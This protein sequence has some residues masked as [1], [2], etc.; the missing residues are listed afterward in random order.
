[1]D[2]REFL[3]DAVL[4]AAGVFIGPKFG[5]IDGDIKSL[6]L[7]GKDVT[8]IIC[9]IDRSG[10]MGN[11]RDSAI[12]SLNKFL[13]EQQK[14]PGRANLTLVF[15][16]NTCELVLEGVDI[17]AVEKFTKE[18]YIPNGSTAL[19]DAVGTSIDSTYE[20]L[21]NTPERE[22][23]G[24]IICLILT[25]GEENA[26]CEY[27]FNQIKSKITQ[28]QD[29]ENWKFVFLGAN[30]D[31]FTTGQGMGI[32]VAS[33]SSFAATRG[34][35][36]MAGNLA[37]NTITSFRRAPDSFTGIVDSDNDKEK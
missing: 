6:K 8:E 5:G 27:T 3:K 21:M 19:L 14:L 33:T 9:V 20:R 17:Q 30:Q 36:I 34:G 4:A 28:I 22:R 25:D 15:F 1:M 18:T 32:P 13:E 35:V 23:T 16:S 11:I 7:R 10:S 26:S 31:A 37:S 12:E 24:K 2:R 29:E